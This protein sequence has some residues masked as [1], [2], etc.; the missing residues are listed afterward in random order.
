MYISENLQYIERKNEKN[1]EFQKTQKKI[2]KSEKN[3]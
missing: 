1:V 3:A 2:K